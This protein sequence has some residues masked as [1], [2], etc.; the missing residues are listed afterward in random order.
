MTSE[1]HWHKL[2]AMFRSAPINQQLYPDFTIKV[3]HKSAEIWGPVSSQT[4]HA[5]GAMHGSV[6]F[7]W[8]D[9]AAYF[10]AAS[11]ETDYFLLTQYF[12][13]Q[14]IRPVSDGFIRAVG[15]CEDVSDNEI[16]ASATLWN[17]QQKVIAKGV[18]IFKRSK[19]PLGPI[20]QKSPD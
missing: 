17:D 4:F 2:E 8:L 5:M 12:D 20:F 13:I 16:K 3:Q 10:A 11:T 1:T 19:Y 14:F 18:G 6:V 7:K 9:D 15:Q